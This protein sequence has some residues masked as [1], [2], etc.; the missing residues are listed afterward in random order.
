MSGFGEGWYSPWATNGPICRVGS[1]DIRLQEKH[2][3]HHSFEQIPAPWNA[4]VAC[5]ARKH[6]GVTPTP[7]VKRLAT[8]NSHGGNSFAALHRQR[9]AEGQRV[10]QQASGG[11]AASDT[12]VTAS[13][14]SNS[15][16]AALRES[17]PIS[18]AA[19]AILPRAAAAAAVSRAAAAALPRAAGLVV[20]RRAAI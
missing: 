2:S 7:V 1:A 3:L 11:P 13:E 5:Q 16:E 8:E 4:L 17:A 9:V 19:A 14:S 20:W 12:Q 18:R 15:M 10:A 6:S